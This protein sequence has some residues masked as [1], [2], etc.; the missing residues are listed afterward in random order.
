[1]NRVELAKHFGVT[2]QTVINWEKDGLPV[3]RTPGIKKVKYDIRK[4]LEWLANR[5]VK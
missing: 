1:M 3:E 4:V 5:E 2:S